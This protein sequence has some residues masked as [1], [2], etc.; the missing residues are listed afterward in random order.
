MSV[1]EFS[2]CQNAKV[3]KCQEC[4]GVNLYTDYLAII[5]QVSETVDCVLL[6]LVNDVEIFLGHLDT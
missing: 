3:P 1:G 4:Q 5:I 2:K 6:L